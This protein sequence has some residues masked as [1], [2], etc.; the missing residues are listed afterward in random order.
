[1]W[2]SKNIELFTESSVL[3]ANAFPLEVI[4]VI[5]DVELLYQMLFNLIGFPF[6]LELLPHNDNIHDVGYINSL[7][8][9]EYTL[10]FHTLH[11]EAISKGVKCFCLPSL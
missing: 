11:L 1:M 3:A 8:I 5:K 6:I 10:L 9:E 7:M 2:N 4:A